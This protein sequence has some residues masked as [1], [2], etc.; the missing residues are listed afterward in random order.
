MSPG[1]VSDFDFK[2]RLVLHVKQCKLKLIISTICLKKCNLL[3]TK[4]NIGNIY[5]Y[6]IEPLGETSGCIPI[7]SLG[8]DQGER[9][10]HSYPRSVPPSCSVHFFGKSPF[11]II[12][13]AF[14]EVWAFEVQ[15]LRAREGPRWPNRRQWALRGLTATRSP[16]P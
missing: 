12:G 7:S 6:Q 15:D 10:S 16:S 14:T 13:I 8:D 11:T 3:Q 5:I 1:V 4:L 9:N 2:Y